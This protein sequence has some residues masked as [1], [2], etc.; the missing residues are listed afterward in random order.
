MVKQLQI[1]KFLQSERHVYIAI[2]EHG[3][4]EY[5]I[6]LLEAS[7]VQ[8]YFDIISNSEIKVLQFFLMN[9]EGYMVHVKPSFKAGVTVEFDKPVQMVSRSTQLINKRFYILFH[10]V[11]EAVFEYDEDEVRPTEP[12]EVY[13]GEATTIERI[14]ETKDDVLDVIAL[15]IR[16]R[17]THVGIDFEDFKLK[18]VPRDD[19]VDI[20]RD[21]RSDMRLVEDERRKERR[22]E[23]KHS[24]KRK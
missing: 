15:D 18:L 22:A 9:S 12:I 13:I 7:D 24:R 19:M 8:K 20:M 1:I 11:E 3:K 16:G 14:T 5:D 17:M 10:D 2:E 4:D 6:R 21:Y 23:R